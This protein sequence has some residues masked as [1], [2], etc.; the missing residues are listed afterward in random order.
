MVTWRCYRTAEWSRGCSA[1]LQNGHV[2]V[3]PDCG[4]FTCLWYRIAECSRVCGP[5][6]QNGHVTVVPD[7]RMVTWLWYR[8]AEWKLVS[9][10]GQQNCHVSVLPDKQAYNVK[11]SLSISKQCKSHSISLHNWYVSHPFQ[12]PQWPLF[13]LVS[14]QKTFLINSSLFEVGC[15]VPRPFRF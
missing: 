3:V 5:G 6:L 12:C 13:S 8:T 14:Y 11:F 1:G 2:A 4:M 9:G 10:T 7:C 15:W